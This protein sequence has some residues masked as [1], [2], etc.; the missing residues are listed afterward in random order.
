MTFIE[1]VKFAA[2]FTL[3][4]VAAFVGGTSIAVLLACIVKFAAMGWSRLFGEGA[5]SSVTFCIFGFFV[6]FSSL[7]WLVSREEA[8]SVG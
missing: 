4:I 3:G 6:V 2:M 5:T 7:L 8:P 1:S